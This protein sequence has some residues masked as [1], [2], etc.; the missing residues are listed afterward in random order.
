MFI[1]LMKTNICC[2]IVIL[3]L[4]GSSFAHCDDLNDLVLYRN[5]WS[6]SNI[7]PHKHLVNIQSLFY[8]RCLLLQT[9]QSFYWYF[10]SKSSDRRV[11]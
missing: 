1:L 5:L 10:D 3:L 11:K 7:K 2:A 4:L 9:G 6:T 8:A